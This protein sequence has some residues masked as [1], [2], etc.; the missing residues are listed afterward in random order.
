MSIIL[1]SQDLYDSK[2][3]SH[4]GYLGINLET[5]EVSLYSDDERKGMG[6]LVYKLN[7]DDKELYKEFFH[8]GKYKRLNLNSLSKKGQIL[9]LSTIKKHIEYSKKQSYPICDISN[10]KI[11]K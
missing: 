6:E 7:P 11:G 5:R 3:D 1:K 2:N 8:N 4:F 10:I 9:V